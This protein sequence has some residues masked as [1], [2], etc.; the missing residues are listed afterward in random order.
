[1]VKY[2]FAAHSREFVRNQLVFIPSLEELQGYRE[3]SSLNNIMRLVKDIH[4]FKDFDLLLGGTTRT[5]SLQ[6]AV[7]LGETLFKVPVCL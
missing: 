1:M 4:Q 7:K 5:V 3:V 6:L 2:F